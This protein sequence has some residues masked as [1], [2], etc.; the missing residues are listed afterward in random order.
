MITTNNIK[1]METYSPPNI[2]HKNNPYNSVNKKD[3]RQ[4]SVVLNISNEAKKLMATE[5]INITFINDKQLDEQETMKESDIN[6]NIFAIYNKNRDEKTQQELGDL[7]HEHYVTMYGEDGIYTEEEMMNGEAE[8]RHPNGYTFKIATEEEKKY[9]DKIW[10]K[11]TDLWEFDKISN[12]DRAMSYKITKTINE[13][14]V[15][16]KTTQEE[17]EKLYVLYDEI[18]SRYEHTNYSK[19]NKKDTNKLDELFQMLDKLYDLKPINKE[20]L[21]FMADLINKR[22]SL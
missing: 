1:T 7:F 10:A 3:N 17:K 6:K 19:L 16:E 14:N 15:N 13:I 9:A 22:N 5:E 11:F 18:N 2:I 12:K 4:E 8:R 21:L 20:S